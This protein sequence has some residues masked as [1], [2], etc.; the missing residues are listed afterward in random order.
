LTIEGKCKSR[1]HGCCSVS[2]NLRDCN[3]LTGSS[4]FPIVY[5]MMGLGKPQF[6]G[7]WMRTAMREP[8]EFVKM[9]F[10]HYC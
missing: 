2:E 6:T 1:E 4:P 5:G 7:F 9:D 8:Q 10:Y 3:L